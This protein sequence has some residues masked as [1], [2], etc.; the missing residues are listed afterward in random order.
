MDKQ[1]ILVV[2]DDPAF[3][4]MLR[5]WFEKKDYSI[6]LCI[7]IK[8]AKKA[9]LSK[10]YSLILTDLRLPDGDG[11]MLLTWIKERR[12]GSPVIIMTS[13]AEVP[14]VV[15]AI[16]TGAFDYLEKPINPS[17]LQEKV[18]EALK[19][20]SLTIESGE[21]KTIRKNEAPNSKQ[22]VYGKSTAAQTIFENIQMVAPTK[23]SVLIMG[24][25]GTGKEY[26]AR[27]IHQHS[28]RNNAPF[29]ALD[30]GSLS[31]ELA[32]SELFGHLKGAFT[33]AVADKK[34][35]F[36]M[37]GGGTVFL[38]EIGNLSYDVQIQLLRVLQEFKVRPVGDTNDLEVDVRIIVAT[39]EDLKKAI[40]AGRFRE[41]LYHR[42]N[43]FSI[44]VP[45]L[46]ERSEDIP[47]FIQF[48]IEEANQEL[49][50]KVTGCSK[51]ALSIL[52]Q[53]H[54]SG[55]LR[56]LRN[57][58]RRSVLFAKTNEITLECLPDS[59]FEE[60][61]KEDNVALLLIENEKERIQKALEIAAGNKAAAAR[62]LKI[63]RKT[64]YNKISLYDL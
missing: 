15:S 19:Q 60:K 46:R 33:S 30:C 61:G 2:E 28:R 12:I 13:Y 55:N 32:P 7:C 37:A 54:W 51:D 24:E 34:G 27:M 8:D 25:S 48:F 22:F 36:E 9:L 57:V 14:N 47:Q 58:I 44:I 53:S 45:P 50:K 52:K 49:E 5:S 63:D 18:G 38:D 64:L 26:V 6:D 1:Y 56:E 41:D 29:I 23:M 43:E 31:R 10:T 20:K 39:N 4:L 42:L 40:T 59:M 3:G 35:V 21:K 16:K 11:I 17:V 62:L